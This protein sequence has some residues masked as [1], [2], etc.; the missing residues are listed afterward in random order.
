MGGGDG[1]GNEEV[2]HRTSKLNVEVRK[3][4]SGKEQKTGFHGIEFVTDRLCQ[5]ESGRSFWFSSRIMQVAGR[6]AMREWAGSPTT[7]FT[8]GHE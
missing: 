5:R 3:I 7:N 1:A 8:N 4:G 2:E 6:V